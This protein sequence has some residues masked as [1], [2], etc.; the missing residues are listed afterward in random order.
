MEN[1][2]ENI[3]SIEDIYS[4]VFCGI[5]PDKRKNKKNKTFRVFVSFMLAAIIILFSS[6]MFNLNKS[7]NNIFPTMDIKTYETPEYDINYEYQEIKKLSAPQIA[8]KCKQS[9]VAIFTCKGDIVTGTGSGVVIYEDKNKEYIYIVTCAHV[10]NEKGCDIKIKTANE[11]VFK[12]E[13]IGYDDNV[14]LGVVRVK[15]S[16]L[17]TIEFGNSEKLV[18]GCT[19]YAI[20][21]PGG[22][23]FF[24]SMTQ[25]IVSDFKQPLK[26]ENGYSFT[27]IQHDA[28]VNPGNSGG[29]LVN[30]YG[31]V[32]GIN[33]Q[34]I[35]KSEYEGMSFAIPSSIVVLAI[36]NI[37]NSKGLLNLTVSN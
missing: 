32:I 15:A 7:Q 1:N 20:G 30:E 12:G 31:Q 4:E 27:C 21:N 19:V 10:I 3:Y 23:K 14:D 6:G 9:N 13:I 28:A 5:K 36:N 37:L 22:A 34:K 35:A 26:T 18:S 2:T 25:G 33:S 17:K 29:M 11:K 16:G 24:A 8:N